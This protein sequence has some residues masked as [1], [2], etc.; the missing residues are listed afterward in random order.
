M[1]R[2]SLSPA[3]QATIGVLSAAGQLAQSLDTVCTRYGITGQQYNILRILRDALPGG[4][5]R[6]EVANFCTH[7]APDITRMLDRLVRQGLVGRERAEEDR[8]C[9][10]AHITKAGLKLLGRVEPELS[11]ELRRLMKALSAEELRQ[12][13]RLSTALIE[14]V[15]PARP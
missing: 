5:P 3:Q 12:L 14:K 15:S 9:S 4:R 6:N 13:A 7:R 1:R 8:R 2:G 11:A 10:M